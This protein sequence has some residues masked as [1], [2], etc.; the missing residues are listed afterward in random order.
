MDANEFDR[1]Y[2][3][4]DDTERGYLGEG[5]RDFGCHHVTAQEVLKRNPDPN[6]G[7]L[8]LGAARGYVSKYIAN[9]GVRAIPL[10]IS[11]HCYHTRATRDFILWDITQIPWRDDEK[12][13]VVGDKEFDLVFSNAAFE[14]IP[15]KNINKVF[16]E[17]RR[18]SNRALVGVTFDSYASVT[19]PDLDKTHRLIKSKE[20][21]ENRARSAVP[22]YEIEFVDKEDLELHN[23]MNEIMKRIPRMTSGDGRGHK[24]INMGSHTGMFY[25]GWLNSDINDLSKFAWGQ[26]YDFMILDASKPMPFPDEYADFIFSSHLIEHLPRMHGATYVRECYRVLRKGG[27]L[28][29]ATPDAYRLMTYY[30]GNYDPMS[31]KPLVED[32]P[33]TL[34]QFKHVNVGVSKALTDLDRLAHVLL[35]GH[36]SIYDSITIARTMIDAG[37]KVV[38]QRDPWSSMNKQLSDETI[39]SHPTLSVV[40]EAM[41]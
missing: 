29:I 8:E 16:K 27:V 10:D 41:K 22:G 19:K 37:F 39:V 15:L 21:W 1:G 40:M 26:G 35:A 7:V 18:V 23:N 13:I 5:Y 32:G 24:K 11:A 33:G 30:V 3:E 4:A 2:F 12:Q 9:A 6:L 17:M 25:Y 14:H 36:Q 28:R 20:W 38:Q 34:A 31:K